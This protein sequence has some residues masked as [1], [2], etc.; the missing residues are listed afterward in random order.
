MILER[1]PGQPPWFSAQDIA[2]LVSV[3]DA[4]AVIEAA[5]KSGHDP[6]SD[7]VRSVVDTKNGQL[8]LMPAEFQNSLGVKVTSV[9]P[10][11]PTLGLPRIQAIYLLMDSQTLT[12]QALMDGTSLT[13]LRTS[14]VSAVAAK[15]L[16]RKDSANLLLFGSGPQARAHIDSMRSIRPLETIS[17]VARTQ[18]MAEALSKYVMGLGM[19]S[20]VILSGDEAGVVTA[21]ASADLIVCATTSSTPVF[22]G[23][24]VSNSA[25]VIAVGSHEPDVREVDGGL[26]GRSRVVVEDKSTALRECGDIVMAIDEKLLDST[27]LIS[28]ADLV[29]TPTEFA[30]LTGPSLFKSSGMAWEDLVI[31]ELV[32]RS[33]HRQA[34]FADGW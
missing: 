34:T 1:A 5:L 26:V 27:S 8:L 28:M 9:S 18:P 17:I 7:P 4:I 14:A 12:P 3:S 31:A 22:N 23:R 10:K 20:R 19:A 15:H 6:E 2:S 21:V 25:C 13:L 11:N 30:D 32:F 33:D 29:N 16:S 24:Y